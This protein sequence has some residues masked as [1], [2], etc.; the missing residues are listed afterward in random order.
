MF[1]RTNNVQHKT[2]G[3]S[4]LIPSKTEMGE[5]GE[6]ACDLTMMAAKWVKLD[7]KYSG[8][9]GL[10]G[11]YQKKDILIAAEAKYWKDEPPLNTILRS[12]LVPK[13]DIQHRGSIVCLDPSLRRKIENASRK[14]S[15]YLLPYGILPDGQAYCKI[16]D[17]PYKIQ[18]LEEAAAAVVIIPPLPSQP[19]PENTPLTPE[20]ALETKR[21]PPRQSLERFMSQTGT[22]LEDLKKIIA[23]MEK[24]SLKPKHLNFAG[25]APQQ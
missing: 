21:V 20:P 14:E 25:H 10:D 22:S 9:K 15:L 17:T 2:N 13:F 7:A 24:E 12:H 6:I 5:I 4:F 1:Y 18:N 23:E 8:N 11:L 16:M 3:S 19:L